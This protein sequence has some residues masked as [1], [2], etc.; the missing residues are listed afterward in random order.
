MNIIK[1]GKR[2]TARG[3][4]GKFS[5]GQKNERGNTNRIFK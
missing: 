1:I 3:N 5:L 2:D 4:V